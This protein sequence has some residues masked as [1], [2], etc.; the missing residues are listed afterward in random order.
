VDAPGKDS[1][2]SMPEEV[3]RPNP[4]RMMLMMM[5]DLLSSLITKPNLM[6]KM[7]DDPVRKTLVIV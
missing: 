1:N 4:W 2:T 7:D 6:S 3:K 5:M